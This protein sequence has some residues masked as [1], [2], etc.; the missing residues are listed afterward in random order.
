MELDDRVAADKPTLA[1]Q[2][3]VRE[4]RDKMA[5]LTA[6]AA[7]EAVTTPH[8]S[9]FTQELSSNTRSGFPNVSSTALTTPGQLGV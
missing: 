8:V 3:L 7:V 6:L 9:H 1:V 5:D 2:V 4:D